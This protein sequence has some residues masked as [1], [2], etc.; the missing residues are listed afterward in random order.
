MC[1]PF[2][3]LST[4]ASLRFSLEICGLLLMV[5]GDD[6]TDFVCP[7]AKSQWWVCS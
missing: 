1:Y 7:F 3:A 4:Y 5:Y 6:V 2:T